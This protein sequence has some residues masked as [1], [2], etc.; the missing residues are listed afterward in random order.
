[1]EDADHGWMGTR[2][3]ADDAAF[4]ASVG[5]DGADFDQDTVAVHGRSGGVRSN[6]YIAGE[7]GL[8]IGIER[9]GVGN[10]E[11]E[12]VAMHRQA[13]DKHVASLGGLRNSIAFGVNLQQLSFTYECVET[14]G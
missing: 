2:Q 14:V 1:M 5:A 13:A 4:G 6:E 3:R 10:H 12:A 7:A 8:Q 11:A 9:S